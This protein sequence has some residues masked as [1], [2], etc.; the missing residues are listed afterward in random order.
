MRWIALLLCL[1]A[2]G[3]AAET[4]RGKVVKIADGDTLT[5]LDAKRQE[6]PEP[7]RAGAIKNHFV[8]PFVLFRR[9]SAMR[10]CKGFHGAPTGTLTLK[11]GPSLFQNR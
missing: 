1:I 9:K 11:L 8:K 5:I 3:V 4:I 7:C 6:H 2:H 10:I